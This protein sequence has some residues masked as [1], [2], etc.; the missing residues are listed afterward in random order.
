MRWDELNSGFTDWTIPITKMKGKESHTLPLPAQ[1]IT[2]LQRRAK[3]KHPN[4]FVFPAKT[5]NSKTGHIAE[6]TGEN[7]FWRRI[8]RCAGLYSTD[9]SQNLTVHDLRR[10]LASWQI[11]NNV[12][13]YIV[14]K[15]LGHKS[16]TT[17]Q[18]IYAYLNSDKVRAGVSTAAT[19]L[20]LAS[21]RSTSQSPFPKLQQFA[22][23]KRRRKKLFARFIIS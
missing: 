5:K 16:I 14:S 21:V 1:S 17:T 6:K 22:E 8:T 3:N 19:A 7:S 12:D 15:T 9:K 13:L 11:N 20:E 18:K 10:S 23:D 2:I 4:G